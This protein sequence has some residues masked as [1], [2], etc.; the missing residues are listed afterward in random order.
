MSIDDPRMPLQPSQG[1]YQSLLAAKDLGLPR[2]LLY[3]ASIQLARARRHQAS[4][5][6]NSPCDTHHILCMH[7]PRPF[8][9]NLSRGVSPLITA[10][11]HHPSSADVQAAAHELEAALSVSSQRADLKRL[12][13]A[14]GKA[15]ECEVG[16]ERV[17]RAQ[18]LLLSL[19]AERA[20]ARQR[21]RECV[22]CSA[23]ILQVEALQVCNTCIC[24]DC[25]RQ[26]P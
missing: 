4:L 26:S 24:V 7:L 15:R 25:D 8:W 3:D 1:L 20:A 18:E 22:A 13:A 9:P 23:K 14:I 10:H 21:L 6:L 12:E 17:A 2:E 5:Q 19:S 11:T 16:Q